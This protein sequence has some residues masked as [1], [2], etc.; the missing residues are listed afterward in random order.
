VGHLAASFDAEVRDQRNANAAGLLAILG[1]FVP[2]YDSL[3]SSPFLT[4]IAP[5]RWLAPPIAPQCLAAK[6]N[7]KRAAPGPTAP[8]W[9][10]ALASSL[11]H[12]R[13]PL[14]RFQPRWTLA[15]RETH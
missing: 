9:G 12:P 2:T 13:L 10:E 8:T 14:P 4:V 1:S 15:V 11:R 5:P 7:A 3:V 6:S